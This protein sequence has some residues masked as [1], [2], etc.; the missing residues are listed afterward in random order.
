MSFCELE[1]KAEYRT[2]NDDIINDF[3]IPLLKRSVLYKRAVGFFSSTA[4]AEIAQGIELLVENEG[5]ICLIA[6]PRLSSED[7]EAIDKGYNLRNEIIE[8]SLLR[9]L[10]SPKTYFEEARLNLLANLIAEKR[11]DIKIA[12]AEK[13]KN[14]GMYHE[15]MG[16]FYDSD[17]NI[18][19]FSGSMNETLT[20]MNLN[21][22]AIDVFCSWTQDLERVIGKEKAFA[23]IWENKDSNVQVL[24]FPAVKKMI[25]E[26]YKTS[27]LEEAIVFQKDCNE[28][29]V[30]KKTGEICIPRGVNLY[31]YQE[32][33]INEWEKKGF[34]GIFDMATG[35]GKTITGLAALVR[36]SGHVK[37]KLAIVI[38]CPFQ[39]LVDQ[40]VEDL[41]NFNVDPIIAHSGSEQK[42]YKKR[43]KNAIF[44]FV[45]K[46]KKSIVIICTNA[47]FGSDEIQKELEK[48]HGNVALVVDEAHY[49]GAEK[50][51]KTLK[52]NFTYRLALSATLERHN[53][54]DGTQ[55]L[56]KYFGEKCIEYSIARA[57]EEGK[58]TPYY[59][60]PVV[61]TLSE[62][63]LEKYNEL[64]EMIGKC[65]I[66]DK[67]GN[68]R[69][70]ERGKMLAIAR[71][72]V[73]A[74]A[75]QKVESL[76]ELME[77]YV[78]DTHMLVYCGA[79]KLMG[80]EY[81]DDLEDIR[82]IDYIT[83]KLGNELN[84]KVAQ[85]TSREDSSKRQV[86]KREFERGERL[87]A[88]IAIKC[89]D[90]GVNIPKIKTAFILA[91]TTNPKE[92]IQRRGRVLRLAQGKNSATI[93][94]FITLPR[95]LELVRQL[96]ETEMMKDKGLVKNEVKRI[97]E[98]KD[99]ALNPADSDKLIDSILDV[100]DI[101]DA[102]TGIDESYYFLGGEPDET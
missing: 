85:F 89:L 73:V 79:T 5:E 99:L 81:D 82:Q 47:T 31:D 37:G 87:Q 59:Y 77:Q 42:D 25:V 24:E 14:M 40:W 34:R 43:I 55:V 50:L 58:L 16:L 62:V 1:L 18:V 48:L 57:I 92:Y 8:K 10:D 53:D 75:V 68:K 52:E 67:K 49:F 38:V 71:S 39:H 6:S 12:F 94:D 56:V 45:L 15:K 97:I 35:T 80:Q 21:Y 28:N 69:L 2:L 72:R 98:F 51:Q 29:G 60:R 76:C 17:G 33:A 13:N 96:T 22:E 65:I 63:E 83:H 101:V 27:S 41:R 3:Y 4:L 44:D 78:E 61:V 66:A 7:I 9:E 20:A 70:S 91:S 11:L 102:S 23:S 95:P 32:D 90:E 36:L 19:A 86:L 46:V 54:E 30:I 64:T 74:G 100:Y 93:Y 88:L 26:K 84:M